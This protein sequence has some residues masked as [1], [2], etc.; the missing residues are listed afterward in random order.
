MQADQRNQIYKKWKEEYESRIKM[1]ESFKKTHK[2]YIYA[3][4]FIALFM[5]A[6]YVI[7]ENYAKFGFDEAYLLYQQF[8]YACPMFILI[9]ALY[10]L[11]IYKCIPDPN[12]IKID[13]Y[14]VFLSYADQNNITKVMAISTKEKLNIKELIGSETFLDKCTII[15]QLN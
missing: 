10:E 11:V 2:N 7:S 4:S 5:Y 6:S 12:I 15:A 9:L 1:H 13:D 3:Y 14:Y 8:M